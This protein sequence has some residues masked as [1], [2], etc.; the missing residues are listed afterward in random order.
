MIWLLALGGGGA[1]LAVVAY[2]VVKA[3]K[4]EGRNEAIIEVQRQTIEA[5]KTRIESDAE[6]DG[7]S[8]DAVRDRLRE[9][10]VRNNDGQ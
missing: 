9:Q 5:A 7:L 2:I 6:I 1:A 8:D 4:N 3:L 10:W